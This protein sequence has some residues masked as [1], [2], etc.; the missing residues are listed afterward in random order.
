MI[1]H[2][3]AGPDSGFT[4]KSALKQQGAS[5]DNLLEVD[6]VRGQ[7]HDMLSDRAVYA[8]LIQAALEGKIDALLAGPNCRSRSLLRHIPVPGQP[9][10]PR[11][12]RR[13]G[14][15]EFGIHDATEEEKQKLHDDDVLMWR[16]I[17]LYM[18]ASY[19][20]RVRNISVPVMFSLE[21][22]ASRATCR[23]L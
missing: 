23:R 7:Q 4:L 6:V 1:V 14:G 5:V 12:I 8:G 3:Y 22:P 17:F 21:Q 2:L 10:A 13:W 18:V 9:S 16:T 11:P 15:E 19:M 20:R